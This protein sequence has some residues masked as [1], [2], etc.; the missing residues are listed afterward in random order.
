[1]RKANEKTLMMTRRREFAVE[2]PEPQIRNK[3]QIRGPKE[4]RRDDAL[5]LPKLARNSAESDLNF[6]RS[7]LECGGLD[8]AF[9]WRLARGNQLT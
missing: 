2:E 9:E 4:K 6:A 7:A 5:A 3:A 8:A 1:M